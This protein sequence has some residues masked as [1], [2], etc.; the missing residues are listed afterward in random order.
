MLQSH[1]CL[2]RVYCRRNKCLTYNLFFLQSD[3][4]YS[5]V[6]AYIESDKVG[7]QGKKVLIESIERVLDI[8]MHKKTTLIHADLHCNNIMIRSDQQRSDRLKYKIGQSEEDRRREQEEMSLSCDLTKV[9]MIDFEKFAYGPPG[10]DIGQFLTNYIYFMP[11]ATWLPNTEWEQET[12]I[13]LRPY[14]LYTEFEEAIREM[15]ISYIEAFD[16]H[17]VTMERILPKHYDVH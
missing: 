5:R 16:M 7:E 2:C 10:I 11:A 3:E 1:S 17:M 12:L 13:N 8:Y 14:P 6:R 15:W 4:H 9:R